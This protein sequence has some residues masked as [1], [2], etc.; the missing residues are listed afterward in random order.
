VFDG[1]HDPIIDVELWRKTEQLR[2]SSK[3]SKRG[4]AP[5][6]NHLLSGG[7]L[8]CGRCG[9]AMYASTRP[10]RD[11]GV[12][13]E[14][15][16][17]STR[18]QKGLDACP[19]SPVK[20]Q[21]I[22][23]AVW[24]FF[25]NVGLDLEATKAAIIVQTNAK[26]AELQDHH[27]QALVDLQRAQDRLNRVRG[28]F[29]DGKMDP[30][31]WRQQHAELTSG[32]AAA[33]AKAERFEAQRKAILAEVDQIDAESAV[34]EEMT[35]LRAQVVG[36]VRDG[37]R[38]GSEALRTAIRRVFTGFELIESG[39]GHGP[40]GADSVVWQ[41]ATPNAGAYRLLPHVRADAVPALSDARVPFLALRKVALALR[42]SDSNLLPRASRT[43]RSVCSSSS[44]PRLTEQLTPR[45]SW[46]T[47]CRPESL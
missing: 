3:R 14:A 30:D 41:G 6:A 7:M 16:T 20:R 12:T 47:S 38:G 5:T 24:S 28:H 29:Q 11:D 31:D 36:E 4:R 8:R 44:R 18:H 21:P 39:F 23:E 34:L 35:A 25:A 26:L 10:A 40:V 46:S 42:G 43:S 37:S 15:Y 9:G 19:Q 27:D 32:L 33:T 45:P 17:C 22:D 2:E 13:W 1:N